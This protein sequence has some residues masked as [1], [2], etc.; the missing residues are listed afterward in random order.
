MYLARIRRKLGPILLLG[1][2]ILGPVCSRASE[3]VWVDTDVSI[4]LP[5]REVD[6]GFALVLAFHSRELAIAGISTSYGNGLLS[7]TDRIAR[8]M[9]A[10]FGA[11]A[12]LTTQNVYAGVSSRSD[13]GKETPA[14]IALTSALRRDALI[15]VALGPLT[16]LATV[17]QLHPELATRVKRVF[18]VGGTSP[19]EHLHAGRIQF[20]RIHDANV[21]KDP[22]AVG[23]VLESHVPLTL[24]PISTAARLEINRND[25]KFLGSSDEGG[26]YLFEH[27]KQWLWFWQTIAA[28][29]AGPIFDAFAVFAATNPK[30]ILKETRFAKLEA[31]GDL[32]ATTVHRSGARPVQ[33]CLGAHPN[34]K[35]IVMRRLRT[36]AP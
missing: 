17:L 29:G 26:G 20:L 24:V 19:D 9:A 36:R 3:R 11:P 14:T 25:L 34:M 2:V 21:T 23:R 10:R 7:E 8:E 28:T 1:A 12:G 15:Y 22:R 16:N 5:F 32:T 27:S 13:L 33:F 18:F 4:G 31:N 35:S 6:D 30:S